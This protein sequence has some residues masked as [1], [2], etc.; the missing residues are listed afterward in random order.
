MFSAVGHQTQQDSGLPPANLALRRAIVP[1]L[2]ID[3][4]LQRLCHVFYVPDFYAIH[5]QSV[6]IR[7]IVTKS[8]G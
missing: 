8:W 1:L 5:W 6:L 2:L 4:V 3:G 7:H